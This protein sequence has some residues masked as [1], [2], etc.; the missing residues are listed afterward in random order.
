MSGRPLLDNRRD[1]ELFVDRDRELGELTSALRRGL[2]VLVSGDAGIGKTSL[3][4]HFRYRSRSD[5]AK[6]EVSYARGESVDGGAELLA[7]V[8]TAVLGRDA[9]TLLDTADIL[10]ALGEHA[11]NVRTQ[12][13]D[14][15]FGPVIVLDD[16]TASAGHA[17]F[18]QLRDELWGTGFQW[19]VSV[20]TTERG[21]LLLPPADAFFEHEIA[22]E[23]LPGKA[24][25]ELLQR[26]T[27][28]WST[29]A[30]GKLATAI[31]G[32][33]RRLL[34]AARALEDDPG[35]LDEMLEAIN[36]RDDAIARSGRSET[37]LAAELDAL[38]SASASDEAL[39]SRLSW[40]RA[41]A[42]QVLTHLEELGLVQSEDVRTGRGRPR[43]VYRLTPPAVYVA[44]LS[45]RRETTTT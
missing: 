30:T 11:E 22:L 21:G 13:A 25:V 44:G 9:R 26:R 28:G 14:A 38:S 31:G 39:L 27:T 35:R 42:V 33:P 40:T 37:M 2:N 8:A 16:V 34:A 20:R 29:T 45:G 10:P 7:V 23:P 41:R 19:V 12:V 43:K 17:L 5:D 36:R 32:N 4:H 3:L 18:G 1:A 15:A 6:A 24:A